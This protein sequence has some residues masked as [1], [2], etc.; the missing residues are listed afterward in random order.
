MA[1]E[2]SNEQLQ[3]IRDNPGMSDRQLAD[4]IGCSRQQVARARIASA[5][6]S[7]RTKPAGSGK[8]GISLAG[9]LS[10]GSASEDADHPGRGSA[11]EWALA[12]AIISLG[13]L[14][15]TAHYFQIKA[16]DPYFSLPTVD[17][18]VY[19]EWAIRLSK[20]DWIGTDV[21]EMSPGYPYFLG[22]LYWMFG[23]GFEV[24]H[25]ANAVLG[26]LAVLFIWLLG[27]IMFGWRQA[28]VAAGF[29]ALY[30]MFIYT[31][32]DLLSENLQVTI[33]AIMLVCLCA[34]I[35]SP[36]WW[37]FLL[38]GV[39]LG[40]SALCRPNVLLFAPLAVLCIAATRL[41]GV[42]W[43]RIAMRSA[44]VAIG[45]IL[46]VAPA[47]IRNWH[48]AGDPVMITAHGGMNFYIGNN[49][50]AA[51]RFRIPSWIPDTRF[52]NPRRQS[53]FAKE[54]AESKLGREL[55]PSEVSSYWS[56]MAWEWIRENPG[57]A[58]SL[59][60]RKF[61]MLFSA[62][63][64]GDQRQLHLDA[65]Y[66]WVLRIPAPTFI[67]V[68]PLAVL[69]L[70]LSLPRWRRFLTIDLFLVSQVAA[71]VIIYTSA[72]Y[73]LPMMP[74]A[75]ALAGFSA[76][77]LVDAARARR[78]VPFGAAAWALALAALFTVRPSEV[79]VFSSN[80]FNLANKFR[81]M[82]KDEQAIELYR[83]AISM[84]RRHLA[85]HNN[86]ALLLA[87]RRET[88]EESIGSWDEVRKLAEGMNDAARVER[89]Q[90]NIDALQQQIASGAAP[91]PAPV[92]ANEAESDEPAQAP[93]A[94]GPRGQPAAPGAATPAQPT[95]APPPP[96][97]PGT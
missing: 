22:V 70:A 9:I 81:D 7:G 48:V 29:A 37:L 91:A 50:E 83:K 78:W 2:L 31:G 52:D 11:L 49:A 86:L 63:E 44:A 25:I 93:P 28:L 47:T 27:R 73:R 51:G 46:M 67:V 40:L 79:T 96:P 53:D 39:M 97:A 87:K 61:Y 38:A 45:A 80:Y 69:G 14:L 10:G 65:A 36:R 74:A 89:A 41:D 18:R 8:A 34:G 84:N 19:H 76:V 57:K 12:S 32:G 62:N 15:R 13:A 16:N 64:V 92:P 43:S 85:S 3:V 58:I 21:F 77:W 90:R 23:S 55:K 56:S 4:K 1:R 59:A 20:G 54:H 75:M 30:P 71:L 26:S 94:T 66:S 35:R 33:N 42:P 6:S 5:P 72:R 24:S 88:L 17:P 95:P 68:V 82:G 60:G